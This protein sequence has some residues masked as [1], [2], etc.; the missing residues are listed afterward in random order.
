MGEV[1]GEEE[2]KLDER[3]WG[4]DEEEEEKTVLYDFNFFLPAVT[5]LVVMHLQPYVVSTA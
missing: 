2:D 5:V 3:M 4:S 1:D